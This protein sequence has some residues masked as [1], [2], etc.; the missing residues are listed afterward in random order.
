MHAVNLKVDTKYSI[1]KGLQLSGGWSQPNRS[2]SDPIQWTHR[3][4][5]AS[6]AR[7]WRRMP[8]GHNVSFMKGFCDKRC[9]LTE[10]NV[11]GRK[12]IVNT[13]MV[14]IA[15]LSLL[16]A[17][18]SSRESAAIDWLAMLSRCA[19]RFQIYTSQ[20]LALDEEY[21]SNTNNVQLQ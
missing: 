17:A 1:I 8:E 5:L 15:E 4:A 7:A 20:I 19:M 13:A 3:L 10:T 16:A 2:R 11:P 21:A 6:P 14:F 18:A 9:Q 12:V